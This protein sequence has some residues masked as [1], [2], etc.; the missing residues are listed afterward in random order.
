MG[1]IHFYIS[2]FLTQ[3]LYFYSSMTL[4]NTGSG[5]LL[6]SGTPSIL[7]E[8]LTGQ[9]YWKSSKSM[10]SRVI[11]QA[12][13]LHIRDLPGISWSTSCWLLLPL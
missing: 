1:N 4:H 11:L 6:L 2:T 7:M 8:V 10:S 12:R 3:I 13:T 9:L 5:L